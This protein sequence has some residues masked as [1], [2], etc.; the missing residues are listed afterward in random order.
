MIC[1]HNITSLPVADSAMSLNEN[2]S[3]FLLEIF[4]TY[5]VA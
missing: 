4:F 1:L 5:T 2:Y 3:P